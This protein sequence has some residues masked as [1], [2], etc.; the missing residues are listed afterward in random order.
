MSNQPP[1]IPTL[2]GFYSHSDCNVALRS[3]MYKHCVKEMNTCKLNVSDQHMSA[4][5]AC[6]SAHAL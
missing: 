3:D 1:K 2:L 5:C 6:V 4:I